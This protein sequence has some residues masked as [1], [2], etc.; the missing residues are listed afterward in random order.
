MI[1]EE[2]DDFQLTYFCGFAPDI[3]IQKVKKQVKFTF[4][5]RFPLSLIYGAGKVHQHELALCLKTGLLVI[6]VV[7]NNEKQLCRAAGGVNF[8]RHLDMGA[9]WS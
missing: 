8:V 4:Y 3:F 5:L 9:V 1:A 6:P 2:V 7:K